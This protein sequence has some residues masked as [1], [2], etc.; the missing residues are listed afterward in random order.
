MIQ[1]GKVC[2]LAGRLARNSCA[3]KS[4]QFYV[5]LPELRLTL[6]LF[7]AAL[8][9]AVEAFETEVQSAVHRRRVLLQFRSCAAAFLGM[10]ARARQGLFPFRRV[11]CTRWL[12]HRASCMLREDCR[13]AVKLPTTFPN[14]PADPVLPALC[15][16]SPQA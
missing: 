9:L 13:F 15:A 14:S 7:S 12:S 16:L 3:G 6:R 2:R 4:L 10:H 5:G 1:Q 8:R 11:A